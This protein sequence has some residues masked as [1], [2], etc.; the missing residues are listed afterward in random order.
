M[1][2]KCCAMCGYILFS[3]SPICLDCKQWG[4]FIKPLHSMGVKPR[5]IA[6]HLYERLIYKLEN[7]E[8]YY[9]YLCHQEYDESL[10][11]AIVPFTFWRN[12]E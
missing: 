7:K 9:E 5:I 6:D 1:A 11:D 3:K 2:K 10:L 4:S 8:I 12:V